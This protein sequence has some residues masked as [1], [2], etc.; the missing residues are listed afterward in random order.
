MASIMGVGI[1]LVIVVFGGILFVSY[2]SDQI[3]EL[4]ALAQERLNKQKDIPDERDK[5]DANVASR[6]SDVC[7]LRVTFVGYI[8]D[9]YIFEALPF[10]AFHDDRFLVMGDVESE[11]FGFVPFGSNPTD[12]SIIDY[13]WFCEFDD[14][15]ATFSW[16]SKTSDDLTTFDLTLGNEETAG[17]TVRFKFFLTSKTD[18]KRAF[19]FDGVGLNEPFQGSEVL[20]F[21]S[22]FPFNFRVSVLLEGVTHDHY[23]L[24]YWS[25]DYVINDKDTAHRFH[26]DL[27]RSGFADCS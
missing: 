18:G 20:P 7:D 4:Q 2:F 3:E 23:D 15:L 22:N 11:H 8:N 6:D 26:Y 21:G 12:I 24:E 1:F 25:E 17:E 5:D 27:C 14:P 19:D 9:E 16:I 10:S 13:E